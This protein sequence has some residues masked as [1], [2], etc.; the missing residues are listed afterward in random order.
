[1]PRYLVAVLLVA[2]ATG[3]TLAY[4]A[5]ARER[6]YRALVAG[7]DARLAAGDPAGAI[8]ALSGAIALRP[9]AMLAW[10]QR[11]EIYRQRGDLAAAV[12]DLRRAVEL[13]PTTTP[14]IERLGDTLFA[15]ERYARAAEQFEAYLALDDRNAGVYYKLA[16]ARFHDGDASRAE[17]ATR[18]ALAIDGNL[19]EAQYLLGLCCLQQGRSREAMDTMARAVELAPALVPARE[20]LARLYAAHDRTAQA[21]Q[22]FEA[23]V[24][25]EPG[26]VD[27]H[28]ALAAAYAAAGRTD[29]A[30]QALARASE[31]FADAPDIDVTLG[32]VWLSVA[33]RAADRVALGKALEALSRAVSRTDSSEALTLY[34]SA[35][36]SA[37]DRSRALAMLRQAALRFPV[38]PDTYALLAE[39][40]ER[41]GRLQLARDAL[42]ADAA[43]HGAAEGAAATVRRAVRLAGLAERMDDP[44][45]A[46]AWYSKALNAQPDDVPLTER[47]VGAQLRAGLVEAART[48]VTKALGRRPGDRELLA[49]QERVARAA[50]AAAR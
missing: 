19:P 36:L 25:L 35:F 13:S 1:M 31:R 37:N 6:E 17:A 12:R 45:D 27:R 11:G 40:A 29:L 47:L 5:V 21:L 38:A 46:A 16:L 49:L 22:E 9:S 33:Q 3:S 23:L 28:T 8:E 24:G 43:L 26:R 34:G 15:L 20:E 41:S 32:R 18:R 2:V 10:L 39:A 42:R 48:V 50:D 44:L 14:A 30:V 7:A 4:Q